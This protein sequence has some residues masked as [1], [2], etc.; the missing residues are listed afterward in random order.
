LH[1]YA[2]QKRVIQ[3]LRLLNVALKNWQFSHPQLLA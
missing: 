1:L 2:L 3:A